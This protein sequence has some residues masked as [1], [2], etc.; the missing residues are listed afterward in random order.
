MSAN[1][2]FRAGIGGV[3]IGAMLVIAQPLY[4][5][6]TLIDASPAPNAGLDSAPQEVVLTFSHP[7]E[8]DGNLI[9]V[10]DEAD[11]QVDRQDT[12]LDEDRTVLSV[13]LPPLAEGR[14]QVVYMVSGTEL[15]TGLSGQYEFSVMPPR[16]RLSILY[17]GNGEAFTEQPVAIELETAF[18]DLNTGENSIHLYVDGELDAELHTLEHTLGELPPGV[19]EIRAVLSVGNDDELPETAT[20]TTIAIA[21]PDTEIEGRELAAT[22]EPD[23]GLQLSTGQWIGVVSATVVLLGVGV[24]LGIKTRR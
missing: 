17:P 16:P 8:E 22:A 21:Q 14:Y 24:V 11:Q 3:L 10:T 9:V 4:A 18:F 2:L 13:S 5:Q 7:L 23:A 19:H 15:S 20:T 6:P 12:T 1:K